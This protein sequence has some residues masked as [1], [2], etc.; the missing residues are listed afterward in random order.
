MLDVVRIVPKGGI[1]IDPFAG[2]GTTG[3]AAVKLGYHFH[4]CELSP[5]YAEIA[6]ARMADAAAEFRAPSANQLALSVM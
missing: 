5:E 2:S 6:R 3:V 4:G 1:I